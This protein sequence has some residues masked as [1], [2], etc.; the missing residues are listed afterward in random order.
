MD[1]IEDADEPLVEEPGRPAKLARILDSIGWRSAS[2]VPS[3]VVAS[4]LDHVLAAATSGKWDAMRLCA[5]V[6]ESL[7]LHAHPL[8]GS[9]SPVTAWYPTA[10]EIIR[11]VQEP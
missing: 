9:S 3:G 11:R 4:E 5:A 10:A 2:D 1:D 6:A 8:D 7:R